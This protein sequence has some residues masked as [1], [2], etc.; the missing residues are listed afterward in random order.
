MVGTMSAEGHVATIDALLAGASDADGAEG[1]LAELLTSESF[2]DDD[3]TRAAAVAEEYER[4][5]AELAALLTARWGEP[6]RVDIAEH[7]F[8]DDLPEVWED[9][10]NATGDVLAW[11]TGGRWVA[12]AVGQQDQELPMQLLAAVTEIGPP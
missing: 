12:I 2:W 10:A 9:L 8:D 7:L 6:R 4:E 11:Q 3:G 5:R 1:H